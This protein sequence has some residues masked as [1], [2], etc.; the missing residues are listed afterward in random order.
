M[1]TPCDWCGLSNVQCN[2]VG[3]HCVVWWRLVGAVPVCPP[4]SPCRGASIVQFP[5]HNVCIF[6]METPLRGRPGGH[7]G[8]APTVSFEQ[9]AREWLVS[10]GW[11]TCG[12]LMP[13]WGLRV[14]GWWRLGRLHVD[15][16]HR[17]CAIPPVCLY[18]FSFFMLFISAAFIFSM[19]SDEGI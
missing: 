1:N 10:F 11:I 19:D 13:F 12:W 6:G 9:I 7:T 16:W 18:A 17:S 8:T 15:G 14:D 5:A 3:A 4:V 2:A